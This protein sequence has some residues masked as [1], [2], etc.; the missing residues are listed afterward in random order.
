MSKMMQTGLKYAP[1]AAAGGAGVLGLYAL[2]RML[3][4]NKKKE[5][6]PGQPFTAPA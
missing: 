3:Q 6:Q 4:S 5:R 2:H 1:H